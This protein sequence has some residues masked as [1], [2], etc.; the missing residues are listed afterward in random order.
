MLW[1]IYKGVRKSYS[2]IFENL[3][4]SGNHDDFI[5]FCGAKGEVYY[6]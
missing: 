6:L 1:K 3:K 4:K 5:N 2:E